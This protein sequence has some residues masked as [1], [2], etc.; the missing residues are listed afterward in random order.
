MMI[1]IGLLGQS[2]LYWTDR[3]DQTVYTRIRMLL[4]EQFDPCADPD[5]G[6][7]GWTP[8]EKSQKY[9]VSSGS[10]EKSQSY[11]FKLQSPHSM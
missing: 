4:M 10:P 6:T 5:G 8:P 3:P 2:L 7:L 1:E 11:N 9:R